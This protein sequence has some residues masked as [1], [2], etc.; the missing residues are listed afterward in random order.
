MNKTPAETAIPHDI[1]KRVLKVGKV[2]WGALEPK[3][4]DELIEWFKD[5]LAKTREHFGITD[6]KTVIHGLFIE[7]TG[8]VVCETGMS[9][10][11]PIHAQA[12][13]GA[14]NRLVDDCEAQKRPVARKA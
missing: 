14:W 3:S 1:A 11:S 5:N 8:I 7:G 6:E 12:L 10:N 9:P 2:E 13:V 4:D